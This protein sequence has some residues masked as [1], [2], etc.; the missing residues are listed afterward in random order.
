[1]STGT[2]ANPAVI[3]ILIL[4]LISKTLFDG[5]IGDTLRFYHL[6][7]SPFKRILRSQ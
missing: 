6:A 1:M 2:E 7:D 5:S 4:I 3:V